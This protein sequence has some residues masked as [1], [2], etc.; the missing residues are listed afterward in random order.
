MIDKNQEQKKK[1]KSA[2]KSLIEEAEGA[3]KAPKQNK[4]SH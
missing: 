4:P 2:E 3:A 1:R